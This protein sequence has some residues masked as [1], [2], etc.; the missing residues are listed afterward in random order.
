MISI[1]KNQRRIAVQGQEYEI[2]KNIY[3]EEYGHILKCCSLKLENYREIY[4]LESNEEGTYNVVNN[5]EMLE[6]IIKE[7][8]LPE[9]YE[10][11]VL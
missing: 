4:L 11:I 5:E 2:I 9:E 10:D 3:S 6:G 7:D 8:K 1:E